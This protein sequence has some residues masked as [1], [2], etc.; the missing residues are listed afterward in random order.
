MTVVALIIAVPACVSPRRADRHGGLRR[1][2]SAVA[3]TDLHV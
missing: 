1:G 3:S 2:W